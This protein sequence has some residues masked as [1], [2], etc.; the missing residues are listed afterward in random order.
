MF[1]IRR[2]LLLFFSIVLLCI[3]SSAS[4][5]AQESTDDSWYMGK[6]ITSITFD[7]LKNV[8]KSELDGITSSFINKPFTDEL[9]GNLLD[10]LYAVDFFDDISPSAKHDPHKAG[11][12]LLAFVVKEKPVVSRIVFS[13]NSKIR[14]GELR[15]VISLKNDDIFVSSKVLI[16]ERAIRDKYL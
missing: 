1:S 3:F 5:A 10:R 13:G 9:F 2:Q 16:D 12:V 4:L 8:K 15:D 7:G 14:N 6:N 11:G